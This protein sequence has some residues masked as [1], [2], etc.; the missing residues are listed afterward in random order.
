MKIVIL[1][2]DFPPAALG[3]AGMVAFMQA[4]ELAHRGHQ[5]SVITTT[6]DKNNE[7]VFFDEGMSIH[8]IY[9]NIHPRL[10]AYL[11]LYNPKVLKK[12]KSIIE[13]INPDVVHAHNIHEELSYHSLSIA[14]RYS[15]KVFVT[16]HDA[17]TVNNGKLF[18]KIIINSENKKTFDYRV[19]ALHQLRYF[20]LR[21]NPL[22]KFITKY[23]LFKADRVF[24]VSR[25][26]EEALAQNGLKGFQVMH[27]GIDEESFRVSSEK[28]TT[29]KNKY[30]LDGKKVLFFSGRISRAKGIDA[31][32]SLLKEVSKTFPE[33]CLL[34]AG[35][36]NDYVRAILDKEDFS[37]IKYKVIFT[38]WLSR[39]EVA[40]AYH[41][42]DLIPVLSLY[43]DPFP[44]TN[45]EAMAVKKPIIGTCFGGTPEVVRDGKN[46]F[47]IDPNNSKEVF[48]Q[49]MTIFKNPELAERFGLAG[50]KLIQKEFSLQKKI[51][52]LEKIYAY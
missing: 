20:G 6:Q 18:P 35:R 46:G 49:A 25:A 8:V 7:R 3:G 5:V 33:T 41:S 36:E 28:I 47:V 27:N 17:T 11:S 29:F 2:D 12:V 30:N 26:L 9:S 42:S 37:K 32:I 10:K 14:H 38:G 48:E 50:F 40:C 23:Y 39:E 4:R 43:L 51:D 16:L 24:V 44:T 21:Y 1:S 19:T 45:L 34:I 22:A 15:K 13:E 52:E 31:C